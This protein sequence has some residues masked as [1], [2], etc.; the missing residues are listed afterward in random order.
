MYLAANPLCKFCGDVGRLTPSTLVHHM[1]ED[2]A[3]ND[4][5]N[6]LALCRDCHEQ[7]HGR[8]AGGVK[9]GEDGYPVKNLTKK[10]D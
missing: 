10:G 8:M 6:L 2:P 9:Y 1:D 7:L 4:D 5:I 3:N